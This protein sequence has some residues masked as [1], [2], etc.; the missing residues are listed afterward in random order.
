MIRA[1]D[2]HGYCDPRFSAVQEV[3]ARNCTEGLELGA[4]CAATI[5]GEYVVDL[6]AGYADAA[7]TVPWEEHTITNVYS[8]TKIMTALCA[9]LL[10]DR[11]HLDPDAPVAAYW[12]EFAQGGKEGVLVRWL[13][14]HG[15]G[16]SGFDEP[17]RREALFDWDLI[18]GL[19]ARQK[20]WWEPGTM[21]GYHMLTFGYMVGELVR[22][23]SGKTLGG[24]FRDE[25]ALPL[26]VDFHIGL[27]EEH[28]SRV[29]DMV[30][31]PVPAGLLSIDRQSIAGRTI[32]NPPLVPAYSDR[33]WRAAEIPSSNGHGN[34]R[35]VAKVGSLLACGGT[36][37]G[38]RLLSEETIETALVEQYNDIDLVLRHPMRW[39]LGFGLANEWRPYLGPRAFYWGGFGGSWLEM[40]RDTRVCFSYVMN[41]LEADAEADMRMLGLRSAFFSALEQGH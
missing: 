7:R 32:F 29:A 28:E 22:R 26:K 5:A 10:I 24:F 3:F 16:L 2:I 34:A 12:P 9:L 39:G 35:S 15:A 41:K 30:S 25:V 6:W 38:L 13:L 14:S 4:S 17:L 21:P 19:L 33:A 36:L 8:T 11:G 23:I 40:D 27:P 37:G 1:A 20:P 31:S 18:T